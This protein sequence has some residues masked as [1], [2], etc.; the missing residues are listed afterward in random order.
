MAIGTTFTGTLLFDD[1][2][3]L[4][5]VKKIETYL[6]VN[7]Q[8]YPEWVMT[9]GLGHVALKI[10]ADTTGIEWDGTDGID[11][12]VGLINM[13]IENMRND[14]DDFALIGT[15]NVQEPVLDDWSLEVNRGYAKVV[16]A[17]PTVVCPQ[18]SHEFTP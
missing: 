10:N 9:D 13:V 3:K 6:G 8:D 11:N 16:S 14:W 12:M 5:Q 2:I 15:M 4:K 17:A 18:C 7:C 1:D